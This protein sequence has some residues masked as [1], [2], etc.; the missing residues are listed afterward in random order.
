[1]DKWNIEI[2]GFPTVWHDVEFKEYTVVE[3]HTSNVVEGL[4]PNEN[5]FFKKLFIL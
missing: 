1:M 4:N 5:F 3:E 2:T